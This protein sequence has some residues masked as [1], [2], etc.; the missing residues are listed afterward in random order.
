[1]P[2]AQIIANALMLTMFYGL[3]ASGLTLVLGTAGI[4]NFAHGALYMLGAFLAYY[5]FEQAGLPFWAALVLAFLSIGLL[6]IILN[7]ILFRPLTGQF[8][9]T[10][11][12]CLALILVI[13]SGMATF[14]GTED[15]YVGHVLEGT[16]HILGATLSWDRL[17]VII[18]GAIVT[19]G[20]FYFINRTK[21]GTAIRAVSQDREAA[22]L[23]GVNLNHMSALALAIGCGLAGLAG[24]LLAPVGGVVNPFMGQAV[25][26][27]AILVITLG[28]FG[29]VPG[30][31]V[32]AVFIGFVES[33]G[34]WYIGE[35][36]T[37]V[38]FG[39]VL[40][41]LIVRPKGILGVEHTIGH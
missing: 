13:E 32:G 29:S 8:F 6:G 38:L 7:R 16:V 19:V 39:L 11:I 26:F 35:W 22:A 21:A 37:A 9:A 27:K 25:L 28:G 36:I 20:L 23:Q 40:L 15:R 24:V 41:V 30:A 1:M 2:V 4:V 33:F 34:Y 3:V 10:V 18:I 17:L 14:V 5:V 12:V 31:F